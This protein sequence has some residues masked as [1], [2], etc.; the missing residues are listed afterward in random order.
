MEANTHAWIN[1]RGI[2]ATASVGVLPHEQHIGQKLRID[3]GVFVPT[4][5]AAQSD[6]LMDT[7]DWRTL[8]Q[9]VEAVVARKHYGLIETLAE[10]LAAEL[11]QR[12]AAQGV[13]RVRVEVHKTGCL[14]NGEASVSLERTF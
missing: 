3:I 14:V 9:Q 11:G 6:A 2:D 1:L 10:A 8:V 13:K 4:A 5:Q 7:P 12:Q